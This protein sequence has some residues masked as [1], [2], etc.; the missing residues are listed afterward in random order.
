[1]RVT[2]ESVQD[3]LAKNPRVE[4]ERD[5]DGVVSALFKIGPQIM[6]TVTFKRRW[7]EDEH[8]P[9]DRAYCWGA[10]VLKWWLNEIR[11]AHGPE[12]VRTL[13]P[14]HVDSSVEPPRPPPGPS[15]VSPSAD[16]G[17]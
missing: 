4:I 6:R 2:D 11:G 17:R 14:W 15:G 9:V 7:W 8:A 3:F 5:K 10:G 1:M 13:Y 16:G 12:L